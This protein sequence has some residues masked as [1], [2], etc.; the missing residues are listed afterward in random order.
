MVQSSQRRLLAAGDEVVLRG[1]TYT[2]A[3][4]LVLRHRGQPDKP[5]VIRAATGQQVVFRRPDARQNTFNL[6]GTQHLHLIGIEITGGAAGIRIGPDGKTQPSDVRLERLHIHHI[7]GVAVTCNHEGGLYQRMAFVEN[8]IHHTSGHGEAF[9]LGGNDASAI[10]SNSLVA[11]NYIHDLNGDMISQGDGIELKQ[12]SFGNRVV[13]NV[14][15]HTKYP[16]VTVYGTAGNSRNVIEG[17]LIWGTGDHGI[18]AAAD[19]VIRDNFI[20]NAGGCGIYSREHQGARPGNLQIIGNTIVADDQPALRIIGASRNVPQHGT[21]EVANNRWLACKSCLAIRIDNDP[22]IQWMENVGIGKIS[23]LELSSSQ[24]GAPRDTSV[25]LPALTG[26]PAW[27]KLDR[28]EV[29]REINALLL[30]K[31][32]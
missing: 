25:N 23:G 32:R 3:R 22:Q 17:N 12:G 7:G 2:D 8:E 10:F 26:H 1:G 31:Q 14:I 13:G 4:R 9:Y 30:S 5:I 11:N 15:H 24:W 29:E 16:G 18:Q 28:R 19:A 27:K 6:E 20:W 21:I